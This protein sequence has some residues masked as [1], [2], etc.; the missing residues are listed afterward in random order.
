M[1]KQAEERATVCESAETILESYLKI[2][3]LKQKFKGR[4]L[5]FMRTKCDRGEVLLFFILSEDISALRSKE[6]KNAVR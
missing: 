5:G 3:F 4:I 1:R 2:C 6:A